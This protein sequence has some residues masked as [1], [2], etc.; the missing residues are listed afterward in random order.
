MLIILK[1][2][3]E[4]RLSL[5]IIKSRLAAPIYLL[6]CMENIDKKFI[7]Y[8]YRYICLSCVEGYNKIKETD[9]IDKETKKEYARKLI[10]QYRNYFKLYRKEASFKKQKLSGRIKLY[11]FSINPYIIRFVFYA[12]KNFIVKLRNIIVFIL[13]R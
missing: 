4:I 3:A 13:W 11:I 10:N 8:A 2:S 9:K 5:N 1:A 12:L 7:G 6:K